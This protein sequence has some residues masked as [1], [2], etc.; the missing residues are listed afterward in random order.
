MVKNKD[1]K[2]D[3]IEEIVEIKKQLTVA[4]NGFDNT[5]NPQLIDAYI[6]EMKSLDERFSYL[7]DVMKN[8]VS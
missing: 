2:Q 8:G 7:L 6:Y 3:I 5:T 1:V 4:Q